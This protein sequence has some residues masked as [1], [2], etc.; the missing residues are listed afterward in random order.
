MIGMWLGAVVAPVFVGSVAP[1]VLVRHGLAQLARPDAGS[2]GLGLASVLG[3]GAAGAAAT[4]TSHRTEI[5]WLAPAL[6]VWGCALVAAA[7]CDAASQ[8]IPTPLVRRGGVLT[9]VFLVVGLAMAGD[10]PGL[11]FSGIAATAAW[12]TMLLCWRFAGA[13]FGD[14]R[15]ATL[16]GL[17]LGHATHRGL[18]VAFAAFTLITVMQAVIVLARGGNRRTTF[19]YGPGLTVGFLIAAAV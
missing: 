2:G 3:G 5:W 8:R 19:A 16:G 17:G 12:L 14:V 15:L 7:C 4:A 6:L 10:W 1:P 11:V 18:M 9:C 13:G